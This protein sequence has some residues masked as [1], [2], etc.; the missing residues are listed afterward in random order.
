MAGITAATQLA[1]Y[2]GLAAAAGR[3]RRLLVGNGSATIWIGRAAGLLLVVV[4]LATLW[5]GVKP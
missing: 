4:S 2:G 3:A 5:E 1:V